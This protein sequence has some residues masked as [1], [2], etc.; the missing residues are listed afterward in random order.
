MADI[1]VRGRSGRLTGRCSRPIRKTSRR[2]AKAA[3][4]MRHGIEAYPMGKWFLLEWEF[5]DDP[6]D[7]H[8]LC[9]WR[10]SPVTENGQHADLSTFKW[11]KD[12]DNGKN[13]VSGFEE[14]GFGA[15]VWGAVP[16]EFDV[17]YDDFAVDAKRIGPVK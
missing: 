15:R 2:V 8:H 14:F 17:Y 7:A 5:N 4:R 10:K 12:S 16:H 13:L 9:G 11:P 1:Q 6:S 3:E